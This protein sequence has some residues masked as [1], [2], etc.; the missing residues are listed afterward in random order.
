MI[1][2][3]GHCNLIW[4]NESLVRHLFLKLYCFRNLFICKFASSIKYF[5]LL[6]FFF[7]SPRAAS[8]DYQLPEK[9]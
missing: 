1:K 6:F 8:D 2:M 4:I 9:E 7:K 5:S 3:I